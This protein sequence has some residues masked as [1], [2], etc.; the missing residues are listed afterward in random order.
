MVKRSGALDVVFAALAD[1][2]RRAMLE[3]PAQGE[4][5]VRQTGTPGMEV[6]GEHSCVSSVSDAVVVYAT[7]FVSSFLAATILPLASE[8]VLFATVLRGYSLWLS[9]TVVTVGNVLGGCTT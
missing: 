1:H 3:R 8:P 7:L 9:T 6:D 5:T 2:T 4:R